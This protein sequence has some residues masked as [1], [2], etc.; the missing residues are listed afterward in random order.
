M[1]VGGLTP[2]TTTDFPGC[3]AAVVFCQ[4]CPWNCG[5]CHN[6][7]LIPPV[8][9]TPLDWEDVLAFL[10]RRVGLLDGVVFSGGEPTL[11]AGLAEAIRE[12]RGLGFRIGLHSASSYPERFAE[13][14]PL[15][16]WVGFDVKG[17]FADY[18]AITGVP[19]SGAKAR[20]GL[21]RL[22]ES[23]VAYEVRTTVHPRFHS[24]EALLSLSRELQDLGVQDYVLQEFRSQ[25]CVAPQLCDGAN[26]LIPG[27]VERIAPFFPSFTV[28]RA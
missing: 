10:K 11:Q 7:H 20:A 3:L 17:L 2:L 19:G 8:A 5:Y 28:R 24:E 26:R 16:D 22:L 4:G 23:G 1:Q 15:L 6:P 14:L 27:I 18:A 13:V 21:L 12:V 9:P 25:G